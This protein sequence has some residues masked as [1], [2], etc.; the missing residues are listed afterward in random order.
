MRTATLHIEG[1]HCGHCL[2]AVNRALSAL[3]GVTLDSVQMGRA[4]VH[5]D[6]SVVGA[7]AIR[8][9]VAAAGYRASLA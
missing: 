6:E 5:Y 1:M 4:S 9:A 2:N 7:D 3:P 8:D